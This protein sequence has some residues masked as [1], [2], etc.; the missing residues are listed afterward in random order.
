MSVGFFLKTIEAADILKLESPTI[1]I[2][3]INIQARPL[4]R[5]GGKA[6]TL[7]TGNDEQHISRDVLLVGFL[8]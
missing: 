2:L 7:I 1:K 8:K 6:Q 4:G 3:I 5:F